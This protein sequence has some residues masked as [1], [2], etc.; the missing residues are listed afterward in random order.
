MTVKGIQ[1][2]AMVNMG[3]GEWVREEVEATCR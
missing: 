2:L 1:R 3:D